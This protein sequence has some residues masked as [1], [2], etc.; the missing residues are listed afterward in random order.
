MKFIK[1]YSK[2]NESIQLDMS[3]QNL[4]D[5]LESLV[6]WQDNLLDSI[7]KVSGVL[8]FSGDSDLKAPLERLKIKGKRIYVVGVRGMVSAELH[9]VK[10]K[11][12]DFGKFYQGKRR[13]IKSENP[14]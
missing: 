2:F 14:R 11:Y 1:N 5:L 8:V 13:Y 10:N 12:I 7:E 6:V 3:K 4:S 9:Q